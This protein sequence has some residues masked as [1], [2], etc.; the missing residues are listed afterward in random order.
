MANLLK[1]KVM[2]HSTSQLARPLLYLV[3]G[4]F[5]LIGARQSL[6]QSVPNP[7][8]K[9]P[10]MIKLEG[11]IKQRM[12]Y[13]KEIEESIA[14]TTDKT[15]LLNTELESL[16]KLEREMIV[17]AESYPEVL[18]TLHSQR[19]QLSIDLAG[20]EAR[21]QAIKEAVATISA[22]K[23]ENLIGPLQKLVAIRA[24]ELDRLKA[25]HDK[26]IISLDDV[27]AAEI[28]L[29]ESKT[30]LAQKTSSSASASG[31]LN[32]QLLATSLEKAE[33]AARL[34]KTSSLIEDVD[35]YRTHALKVSEKQRELNNLGIGMRALQSEL[36]E[37]MKMI[38]I[39][40]AELEELTPD[41]E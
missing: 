35:E 25:A 38:S 17:S 15:Q 39:Q 34:A 22:T 19:V 11:F 3:F 24:S 8:K 12:N 26:G 9:S 2:N 7:P 29:L 4:I 36:E 37:I 5:L 31:Q 27:R 40:K 21:H 41:E 28:A 23:M 10:E 13:Q 20:L 1:G 18:R 30:R 16:E 14:E 33:K 32:D 6:G